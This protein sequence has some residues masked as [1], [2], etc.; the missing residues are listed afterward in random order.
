MRFWDSSAI[1]PLVTRETQSAE[2]R[3][4]LREDHVMLVW[5][6]TETEILSALTRRHREGTLDDGRFRKAKN[7]LNKLVSSWN[8]VTAIDSVRARARRLLETHPLRAADALQ[9]A[10]ALVAVEENVTRAAF[11]TFD[12]RLAR[13]G[14]K[15]GFALLGPA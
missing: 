13:A 15:E 5:C 11:V 10:A 7:R 14:E 3:A 9:L 2:C 1:V 8:E 4:W 6:L 12:D